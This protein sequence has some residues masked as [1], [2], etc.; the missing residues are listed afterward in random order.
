SK[1]DRH[2]SDLDIYA[3]VTPV[4]YIT[5]A[6]DTTYD[7]DRGDLVAARLG[8]FL[9]DPRP[10]PPTTPLLQHLQRSTTVGISYVTITDRILKEFDASI[11]FRLN[12]QISTAYVGRYDLNAGSF[13]GNRYF[14]RYVSAQKCWYVDLGLIEKVN[15]NEFEFRFLFTLVGLSSSGRT[16][17]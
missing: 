9:R 17:F 2:F 5:F 8:L 12:E 3:R 11:I 14:L 4:P 1:G 15:P 13:I 6:A 7:V 10:L 16:A